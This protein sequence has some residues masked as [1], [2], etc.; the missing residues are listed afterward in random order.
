MLKNLQILRGYL[1]PNVHIYIGLRIRVASQGRHAIEQSR[2]TVCYIRKV[3]VISVKG[4]NGL[5][6]LHDEDQVRF[7][8]EM[9]D[10]ELLE[11][12]KAYPENNPFANSA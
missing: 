3:K 6:E 7:N 2:K 12:C 4:S 11:Y 10:E 5:N 9:H 8:D 1:F